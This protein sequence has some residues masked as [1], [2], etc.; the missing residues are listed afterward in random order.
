M[1]S[2]RSW[3]SRAAQESWPV[4]WTTSWLSRAEAASSSGGW[5]KIVNWPKRLLSTGCLGRPASH[6]A[7][8]L[9]ASLRPPTKMVR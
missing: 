5:R 2:R 3:P 4:A 1:A 6:S 8:T 7:P 9:R